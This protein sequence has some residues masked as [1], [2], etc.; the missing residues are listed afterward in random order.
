MTPS[1]QPPP[2]QQSAR[3]IVSLVGRRPL[4]WFFV[5][6]Y[7]LSWPLILAGV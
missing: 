1:S 7:A 2:S 5:L 6:A 4:V 3:F